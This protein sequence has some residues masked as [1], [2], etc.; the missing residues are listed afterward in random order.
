[1]ILTRV[2]MSD[3][4]ERLPMVEQSD[5]DKLLNQTAIRDMQIRAVWWG[6]GHA[7]MSRRDKISVVCKRFNT[8]EKNVEKIV[9]E[10]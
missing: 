4:V 3:N 5:L 2:A 8:G 7:K 10:L 9:K 1:M 6:L